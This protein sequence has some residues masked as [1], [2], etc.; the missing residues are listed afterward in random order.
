MDRSRLGAEAGIVQRRNGS[1]KKNL[2]KKTVRS[3][4]TSRVCPP[5][6]PSSYAG[7]SVLAVGGPAKYRLRGT[8]TLDVPVRCWFAAVVWGSS[9]AKKSQKDG[10]DGGIGMIICNEAVFGAVGALIFRVE[11]VSAMQKQRDCFGSMLI[12]LGLWLAVAGFA[13]PSRSM[14]LP[15]LP[16]SA[17]ASRISHFLKELAREFSIEH[18]VRWKHSAPHF[19]DVTTTMSVAPINFDGC[20]IAWNQ[21]QEGTAAGQLIYIDTHRFEVPLATMDAKKIT[22]EA[23]HAGQGDHPGIEA[24]DYYIVSLQSVDGNKTV[25]VVDQSTVFN[26]KRGPI[27]SAEQTNDSG[28][29]VRVRTEEKAEILKMQFQG[30]IGACAATEK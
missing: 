14:A 26:E 29:W 20:T 11:K 8:R 7:E 27:S 18:T 1:R 25:N 24:G 10:S 30:A 23:V 19:G 4:G 2:G 15:V 5:C 16:Q 28:A 17:I 6:V 13:V 9:E 22:V 21:M 3:S 12:S